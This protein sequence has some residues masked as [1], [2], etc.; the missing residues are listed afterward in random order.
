MYAT[1]G[2]HKDIVH[3]LL[4]RGADPNYHNDNSTPLMAVC[5]ARS[6]V[7]EEDLIDCAKSL[8]KF[9]AN[10]NAL[11]KYGNSALIYAAKAGKCGLTQELIDNNAE[12]NRANNE[13]WNVGIAEDIQ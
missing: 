1:N 10:V 7:S 8:M 2:G 13:G 11:D 4:E 5:G 12:I 3:Y 6:D 9:G